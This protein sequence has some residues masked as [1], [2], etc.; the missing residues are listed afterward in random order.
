MAYLSAEEHGENCC[1]LILNA[2]PFCAIITLSNR[3]GDMGQDMGY[4]LG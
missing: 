1:V 4:V 2:V 3:R